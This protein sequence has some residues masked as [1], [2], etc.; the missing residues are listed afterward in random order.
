MVFGLV[1]GIKGLF[2]LRPFLLA[3]PLDR[4]ELLGYSINV[5]LMA[6]KLLLCRCQ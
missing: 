6:L 4:C 2:V 1:V 3:F 5:L